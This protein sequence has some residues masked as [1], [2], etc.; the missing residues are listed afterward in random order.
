MKLANRLLAPAWS[1]MSGSR[2]P[3]WKADGSRTSNPYDGNRTAYGDGSRTAYGG[4]GNRTPAWNSGSR[5]P[6]DSSSGY[7][8]F[9][10]G[11]RT[12]AWGG[13]ASSRS[14]F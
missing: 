4:V 1:G 11:S 14:K 5:T 2:T 7:D 9:A 13:A 12:P 8:A 6:Y 10:T 3:A